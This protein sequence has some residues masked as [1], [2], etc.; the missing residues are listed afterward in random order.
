MNDFFS[1]AVE[2]LKLDIPDEFITEG[3][4]DLDDGIENII[5]KYSNH[6]SITLIK[7]NVIEVPFSFEEVSVS[8]IVKEIKT[9]D[10][11]KASMSEGIPPKIL[12]EYVS[13]CCDPLTNIINKGIVSSNFDDNL[14]K[15]DLTPVHKEGETTDKKNYRNISLLDVVAKI[16]EKVLQSQ[17]SSH[18]EQ[19]LSPY[20][21]GYRKG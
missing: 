10:G 14:K 3:P 4:A 9:L 8:N 18:T 1:K 15:A 21:C 5:L 17:I 20:L 6:P 16:F 2:S 11:N 12:K 19:F 13:V 7:E